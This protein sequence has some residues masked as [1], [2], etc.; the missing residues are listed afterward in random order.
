M[1]N[2]CKGWIKSIVNQVKNIA[3]ITSNI[4]IILFIICDK[5]KKAMQFI[6]T[7]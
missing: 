2:N 7:L 4:R 3:F 1:N 6:L 5:C